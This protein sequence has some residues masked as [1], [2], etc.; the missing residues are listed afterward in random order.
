MHYNPLHVGNIQVRLPDDLESD[1]ARLARRLHGNRS[2]AIRVAVAEGLHA[3]RFKEALE[4]YVAGSVS[5]AR[6]AQDA[7]LSL[8]EMAARAASI[9]IPYARYGPDEAARD[10]EGLG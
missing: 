1:V 4:S 10:A 7:G 8:Q 6:A 2:D 5:L 3:L 9:G